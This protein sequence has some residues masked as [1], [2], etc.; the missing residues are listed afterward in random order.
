MAVA[1]IMSLGVGKGERDKGGGTSRGQDA[2]R[3]EEKAREI[4]AATSPFS[5][6]EKT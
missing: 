6:E 1:Q 4:R 5:R 3:D 2:K